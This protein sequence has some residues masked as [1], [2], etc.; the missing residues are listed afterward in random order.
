MLSR[1]DEGGYAFRFQA[2]ASPCEVLI[3]CDDAALAARLGAI[4]QAEARRIETKWSRYRSDN[5]VHAI[6]TADGAAI[7][8]DEETARLIDYGAHLYRLSEA[9]FDLTSGVLRRLWRFDGTERWVDADAVAAVLARVGWQ[10][11]RWDGRRLQME[12]QMEIDFGGIGKEYA[13]DRSLALLAAA[14]AVPVLVN[15]GGDL[16]A[17]G[18]RRDGRPWQVGILDSDVRIQLRQGAVAT[19]GSAYRYLTH[20]GRRYGHLLDARSGY[21]VADAPRAIT[22]AAPT[23]SAAGALSSLALLHGADA[24]RFLE[25]QGADY[26]V[27]P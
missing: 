22:V 27:L 20:A 2:M 7:E 11:V 4:A 16:A 6:N 3:D 1:L 9:R 8:V 10:R 24:C 23:C 14:A 15:Y 25:S 12:P 5:L 21:P 17:S 26:H 13:V 19:S 18:A